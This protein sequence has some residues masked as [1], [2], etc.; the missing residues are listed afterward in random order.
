MALS[1][2]SGRLAFITCG[3]VDDGKSTLLGRLLHDAGALPTDR[4]LPLTPE[5]EPDHAALIDGL[6]AEREQGI[7][8][9][10]AYRP[11]ATPK[12]A[13]LAIDAPG[14][15]QFTRNM[16]TGA[17]N[18]D[19]AVILVD[20][21]K[22]LLPQTRRHSHLVALL[23]MKTVILAVTKMDRV[24]GDQAVFAPIADAFSPFARE[25]EIET[26][27]AIP[28]SGRTGDQVVERGTLMPWYQGP[29]L[30]EALEIVFCPEAGFDA[31]YDDARVATE[32]NMPRRW[33]ED[34]REQF[35]GPVPAPKVD[36]IA[37]A[38]KALS[39]LA[40]AAAAMADAVDAAN[41]A[42]LRVAELQVV[43]SKH[44]EEVGASK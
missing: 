43:V 11:F 13:F 18:A 3:S 1:A 32:Q 36:H 27:I 19:V 30:L 40:L 39:D 12:R 14:H 34:I 38:R 15:E 10:V 21:E 26:V 25:L 28:V 8:I 16:V 22:G 17:S 6:M 42:R 33:V 2:A 23:G 35:L 44:L 37:E 29:T 20:A 9:D 5:G 24:G 41:K 7:T 31:G 4:A